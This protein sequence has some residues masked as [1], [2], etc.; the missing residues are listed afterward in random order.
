M[1]LIEKLRAYVPW[2]IAGII[3]LGYAFF[4]SFMTEKTKTSD[5]EWLKLV[6]IFGSVEAI[7][8]AAVGFIFGNEVNRSRVITAEK[9]EDKAKR[10]K[11]ELAKEILDKL[12]VAPST[13]DSVNFETQNLNK[14]RNMA[15]KYREN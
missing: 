11:N 9:N 5:E 10:E 14:L 3:L 6:Y 1:T 12:P 15:E 4:I 7:V 2:I 8:F 13:P